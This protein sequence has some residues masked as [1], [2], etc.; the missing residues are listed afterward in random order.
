LEAEDIEPEKVVFGLPAGW[1]ESGQRIKSE[2]ED[3]IK[4]IC[5]ELS[6][7]PVGFVV[8]TEAL[9]YYRKSEEGGPIDAIIVGV[10]EET[11]N[12]SLFVKGEFKG[13]FSVLRSVFFGRRYGGRFIPL[14]FD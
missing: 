3:S 5:D 9:A 8:L 11:L 1:V 13:E 2:Y 10:G 14:F 7:K 12:L 4:K 6:L